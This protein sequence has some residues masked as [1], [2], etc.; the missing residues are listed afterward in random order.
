MRW[1]TPGIYNPEDDTDTEDVPIKRHKIGSYISQPELIYKAMH[2]NR[3]ALTV[4]QI[5]R[6]AFPGGFACFNLIYWYYYLYYGADNF[7]E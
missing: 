4:D 6:I 3:R 2:F 7:R 5:S 1:S